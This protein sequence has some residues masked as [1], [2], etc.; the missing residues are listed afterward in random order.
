MG[1][2]GVDKRIDVFATAMRAQLKAT[3]L[4]NLDLSYAPPYSSAKDP[5]NMVGYIIENIEHGLVKQFHFE[6]LE[7]IKKNHAVILL[8]TRTPFE[9]VRGHLEGFI[10]IPIDEL[11]QRLGNYHTH[12]TI[13][14]MCHKWNAQLSCL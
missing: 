5:V 1:A 6:E 12:K 13:Y 3:E 14:V 11:R 7:Q 2:K 4:V 10:N 9:Y 8:D